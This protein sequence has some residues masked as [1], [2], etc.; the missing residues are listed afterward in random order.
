MEAKES[1]NIDILEGASGLTTGIVPILLQVLWKTRKT[2][3]SG[4]ATSRPR[5][6]A[7]TFQAAAS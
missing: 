7:G 6:E 3:R 2:G 1:I 4:Q 5:L